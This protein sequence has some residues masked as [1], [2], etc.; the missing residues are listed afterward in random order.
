MENFKKTLTID[1]Y[2]LIKEEA[3]KRVEDFYKLTNKELKK[4]YIEDNCPIK[5]NKE[6][7]LIFK[8]TLLIPDDKTFLIESEDIKRV[9]NNL[10]EKYKVP[11]NIIIT[12]YLELYSYHYNELIKEIK[13]YEPNFSNCRES[14][15]INKELKEKKEL[16][17][18]IIETL[19]PDY[20]AFPDETKKIR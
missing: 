3:Y 11:A 2:I 12:K 7:E 16:K 4:K 20:D 17:L 10:K 13:F 18:D 1:Q 6:A 5:E 14:N 19:W 8:N 15:I 9:I